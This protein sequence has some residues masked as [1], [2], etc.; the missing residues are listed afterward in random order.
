[1]KTK[2]FY[3]LILYLILGCSS[4][5]INGF[6]E[7]D[8]TCRLYDHVNNF[9]YVHDPSTYKKIK[10]SGKWREAEF[11]LYKEHHISHCPMIVNNDG[12]LLEVWC[13]PNQIVDW[14]KKTNFDL[15]LID[16]KHYTSNWKN[17]YKVELLQT[18]D[19]TYA[20]YSIKNEVVNRT[21]LHGFK[22]GKQ[23]HIE[24]FKDSLTNRQR[25]FL[26]LQIFN[27]N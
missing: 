13:R 7:K 4:K 3:L 6:G 12:A 27:D 5:N 19:S 23:Y 14:K 10:V 15:L 25:T 20:I 11:E 16:L 22:D 1:M 17:N 21:S 8:D 9:T 26:L 24:L 2:L 18:N